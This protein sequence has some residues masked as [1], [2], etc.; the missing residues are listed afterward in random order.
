VYWTLFKRHFSIVTNENGSAIFTEFSY[1]NMGA[2]W[3]SIE[4]PTVV[5]HIA[6]HIETVRYEGHISLGFQSATPFS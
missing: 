6:M 4:R 1:I 2:L 3:A 5:Q